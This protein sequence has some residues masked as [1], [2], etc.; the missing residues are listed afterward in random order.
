M[1]NTRWNWPLA[2]LTLIAGTTGVMAQQPSSH[3]GHEIA[4][5]L[6]SNCHAVDPEAAQTARA[7]VP[8]FKSIANGPRGTP[9]HLAAA[10]ILPHPAM[11]GIPLTRAEIQAVVAYIVSLKK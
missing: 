9:E 4:S 3:D 1:A 8:S 7:D 10:I 11:P 2:V 5:K 6:C